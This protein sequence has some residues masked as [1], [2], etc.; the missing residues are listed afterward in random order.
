MP[1]PL[2]DGSCAIKLLVVLSQLF[3]ACRDSFT[4]ALTADSGACGCRHV[5]AK[6]RICAFR[7]FWGE[8]YQEWSYELKKDTRESR[9]TMTTA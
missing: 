8:E 2:I 6:Y 3:H 4:S 9:G 1:S 5:R 7:F